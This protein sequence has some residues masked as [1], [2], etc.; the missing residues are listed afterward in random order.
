MVTLQDI[1]DEINPDKQVGVKDK[2]LAKAKASALNEVIRR[3][4]KQEEL[5]KEIPD[6]NGKE[7]IK[8]LI[9]GNRTLNEKEMA[10]ATKKFGQRGVMML[11][12]MGH[13]NRA[14]RQWIFKQMGWD[15]NEV[16]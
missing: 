9:N 5:L 1:E 16:T 4:K 12:G 11:E 2:L 6:V 13:M 3:L 7:I 8:A 14:Q 15:S 10:A